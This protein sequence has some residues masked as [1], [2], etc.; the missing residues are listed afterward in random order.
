MKRNQFLEKLEKNLKKDLGNKQENSENKN[1]YIYE[2]I[3][4]RILLHPVDKW[5]FRRKK[6]K[7]IL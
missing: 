5:C 1:P 3:L 4:P 2:V 6:T 7:T